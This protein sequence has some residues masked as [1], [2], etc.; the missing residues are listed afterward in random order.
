M[1]PY[2][3]SSSTSLCSS[4]TSAAKTNISKGHRCLKNKFID[5]IFTNKQSKEIS[6]ISKLRNFKI[7]FSLAKYFKKNQKQTKK[8]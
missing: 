3:K 7:L 6:E 8:C 4:G 2:L 5:N 1:D